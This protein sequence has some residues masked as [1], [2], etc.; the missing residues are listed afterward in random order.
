MAKLSEIWGSQGGE[1]VD[2]G[3]LSMLEYAIPILL[4]ISIDV[5]FFQKIISDP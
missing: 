2:H 3:L 1:D 4:I 5:I